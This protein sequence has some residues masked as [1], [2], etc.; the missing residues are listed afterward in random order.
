MLV[1]SGIIFLAIIALLVYTGAKF[2]QRR[3]RVGEGTTAMGASTDVKPA[4]VDV[5]DER[6]AA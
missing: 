3:W 4:D 1:A 2:W 6:R 5:D